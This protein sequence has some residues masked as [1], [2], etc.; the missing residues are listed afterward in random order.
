MDI[1]HSLTNWVD[2]NRGIVFALILSVLGSAV[3]VGCPITT[4][5]L[6]NPSEKVTVAELQ[7]EDI[8]LT[9]DM[10]KRKVQ[11]EGLLG[12]Y[13]V[14]VEAHNAKIE[15]AQAEI[16]RK[17]EMRAKIVEIVGGLGTAAATGSLTPE[18]GVAAVL[19][20]TTLLSTIGLVYD[21]RRKDKLITAKT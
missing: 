2:H 4:Q 7:S 11:I 20:L 16:Q 13:N 8:V 19:Q 18:A 12:Q 17:A 1:L 3:L 5:S 15:L 6:I 10:D 9:A 14:D 21:N